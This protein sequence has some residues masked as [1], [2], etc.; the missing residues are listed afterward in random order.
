MDLYLPLLSFVKFVSFRCQLLL[1]FGL[2]V[3]I[4]FSPIHLVAVASNDITFKQDGYSE[5]LR[6]ESEVVFSG[7]EF[8]TSMAFLGPDDILVL[9]QGKGTVQ[10]ILHG[11][12]M[13]EPVLDVNVVNERDKYGGK[14]REVFWGLLWPTISVIA[15]LHVMC[16]CIIQRLR[17]KMEAIL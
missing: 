1:R 15:L 10:R 16:F 4:I 8:P 12:I 14:R 13:D 5:E 17:E 11:E 7:L 3:V 9:E 2:S 6:L